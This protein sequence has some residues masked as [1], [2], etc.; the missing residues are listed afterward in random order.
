MALLTGGSGVAVIEGN[1]EA[2]IGQRQ[3]YFGLK[4]SELPSDL[5]VTQSS[6]FVWL[7][8]LKSPISGTLRGSLDASGELEPLNISVNISNGIL[9]P[10]AN[11]SPLAFDRLITYFTYKPKSQIL[12]FDSVSLASPNTSLTAEGNAFIQSNENQAVSLVGQFILN[13]I[14]LN[15]QNAYEKPINLDYATIDLQFLVDPFKIQLKELYAND[16]VRNIEARMSAVVSTDSKGWTIPIDSEIDQI[17]S[18]SLLRY[19]PKFFKPKPRQWMKDNILKADFSDVKFSLR[20]DPQNNVR[21]GT[22][23][24]FHDMTFRALPGFPLIEKANGKPLKF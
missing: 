22:T 11:S 17:S 10:D 21:S 16:V 15:P 8:A 14:S 3:A 4:F 5:L 7:D 9:Q 1:L 6:A 2:H 24:V 12:N 18:K 19:W 23:L 20:Y 13:D